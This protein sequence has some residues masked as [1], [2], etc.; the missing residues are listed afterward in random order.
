MVIFQERNRACGLADMKQL[1]V[2]GS[3]MGCTKDS[4]QETDGFKENLAT[5]S[6]KTAWLCRHPDYC[7]VIESAVQGLN[8]YVRKSLPK[9]DT[10][11]DKAASIV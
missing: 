7:G 4:S 1:M 9:P 8:T 11:N 2:Y 3:G 6:V 5:K 10:Q